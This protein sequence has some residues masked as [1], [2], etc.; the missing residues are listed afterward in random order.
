MVGKP[1]DNGWTCLKLHPDSMNLPWQQYKPCTL[2]DDII[3]FENKVYTV[4]AYG[5]FWVVDLDDPHP[6]LSN[7]LPPL[8]ALELTS[9]DN[10]KHYVVQT[11]GHLLQVTRIFPLLD[12]FSYST[13][14]FQ[15]FKLDQAHSKRVETKNLCGQM[16]FL[17]HPG[18]KANCIYFTDD[19]IEGY[20]EDDS[21]TGSCPG[22][23]DMGVFNLEDGSIE[24]HYQV[25][26][27]RR[28]LP[29][30]IW[31]EPTPQT[32]GKDA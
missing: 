31:I 21:D 8:E 13:T 22:P 7:L 1:T 16:L 27:S 2:T 29:P 24:S 32:V 20:Y 17:G 19:Y 11:S 10:T 28:F 3:Y 6:R 4:D 30:P 15:V 23:P 9:D 25:R 18:C 14:K 12:D 5:A 26:E